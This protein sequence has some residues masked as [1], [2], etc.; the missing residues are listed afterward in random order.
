MATIIKRNEILSV[1]EGV[2]VAAAM[3]EGFVHY[4]SGNTVVP[5][6]GELLFDHPKG[7]AHIKYGY[8][9]NDD[10]Y[11]IKIASGFYDNPKLGIASSQGMMLLFNQ[12]TG[13]PTAVLLDE[14]SLTDIRTAAAGALAAKYFAP[15]NIEAIGI[16]GTGIQARLQLQYLQKNNP[17]KTVWVWG[18]N[19]KNTKKFKAE[20]AS[21]FD[22]HIAQSP[23]EVTK[24]CNLIVTTT[25][26]EDPLLFASD[27]R[28]GTHITA[29]GADTSDK[30]ELES[31]ILKNADLVIADSIPQ[32]K[33]RGEIY[34]A[35]KDG[36]ISPQKVVELGNAIQ[37]ASL[38]RTNE[39]QIS[40]TDLTGVAVQDIMIAKA[41]YMSYLNIENKDY[42]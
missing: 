23:S 41:V 32:S 20:L 10:F 24:H 3:E 36:A 37:D 12:K 34:R 8:I 35:I 38:Q 7:D 22:V 6:V 5:P 39:K 27:I 13:Q 29:V 25:P 26:S 40:I 15:K 33:S 14:G 30:Q 16:I 11:V 4:S 42:A 17:C 2:D 9:K 21:D 19:I 28:P 1:V 18:R 31:E